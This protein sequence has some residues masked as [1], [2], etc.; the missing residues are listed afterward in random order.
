MNLSE[1]FF[2]LLNQSDPILSD[3]EIQELQSQIHVVLLK[4]FLGDILPKRFDSYFADSMRWMQS[5]SIQYTRIEP[6]S[7]F[8]TQKL[9]ENNAIHIASTLE[10][11][12][13]HS[14][15]KTMLIVSHSKGGIDILEALCSRMDLTDKQV[16]GWI[17]LQAPFAGTPV[18]D[19]ATSNRVI[20]WI[21]EV[22]LEKI[23][24]GDRTVTKSM[25]VRDRKKILGSKAEAITVLNQRIKLLNFAT[26]IT[27]SDRSLFTPLRYLMDRIARQ[28]NDGLLP[29]QS[30]LL[31]VNEQA[32]CPF[33]IAPHI[34]HIYPVIPIRPPSGTH[35]TP[36]RERLFAA[37]LK[38]WR[39]IKLEKT[40]YNIG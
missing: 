38:V 8:G 2:T 37:L 27:A 31:K 32:C 7:G 18:A 33:V 22:I 17:S 20:N 16:S 30:Q 10:K 24:N 9:S 11:L 6:D 34:D 12:H 3:S 36:D 5:N 21:I 25:R 13:H 14:P 4:G 1:Q 29:E 26:H 35:T 28:K 23:F 15:N 40:S 19:W 39:E